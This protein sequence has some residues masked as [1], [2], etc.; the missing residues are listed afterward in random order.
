MLNKELETYEANKNGFLAKHK[1]KFVLIKGNK[2]VGVFD[3][4]NDAVNRGYE[5]FGNTPFLVKE[6]LEIDRPVDIVS[7]L[8][9][10]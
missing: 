10:I 5:E 1:G 6:I 3:T 4:S 8:I 2:I 9:A 7:N